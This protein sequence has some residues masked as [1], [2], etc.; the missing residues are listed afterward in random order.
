MGCLIQTGRSR[1]RRRIRLP[2][3][4]Q[5]HR[6][7]SATTTRDWRVAFS[8]LAF[9]LPYGTALKDHTQRVKAFGVD[10]EVSAIM[11]FVLVGLT[12]SL[13]GIYLRSRNYEERI[14]GKDSEVST[15]ASKVEN[16]QEELRR[17]KRLDVSALITLENAEDGILPEQ[18]KCNLLLFGGVERKLPAVRGGVT[19][20]Q[21]RLEIQSITQNEVIQALQCTESSK[22]RRWAL[23]RIDPLSPEYK[24]RPAP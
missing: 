9:F 4:R 18:L 13:T 1:R 12:L 10:L 14:Q 22:G 19:K 3:P 15:L 6:I 16:L 17:A 23:D 2:V 7:H 11:L 21:Y 20:G 5:S 8:L 24:L